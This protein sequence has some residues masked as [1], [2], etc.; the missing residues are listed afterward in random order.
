M[1]ASRQSNRSSRGA[2]IESDM[3]PTDIVAASHK[4]GWSLR[5][6]SRHYRMHPKTLGVALYRS[7]PQR[8]KPDCS[9]DRP[10]TGKNLAHTIREKVRLQEDAMKVELMRDGIRIEP[11]TPQDIAYIEDTLGLHLPGDSIQLRR[12]DLSTNHD[13]SHLETQRPVRRAR[14]GKA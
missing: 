13:L 9:R 10:A 4:R 7:L 5:K 11:S 3:H 8:R 14:K 12:V 1:D 6:L 2:S